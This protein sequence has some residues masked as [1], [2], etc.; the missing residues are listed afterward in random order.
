MR[1]AAAIAAVLLGAGLA[2]CGGDGASPRPP[3]VPATNGIEHLRVVRVLG[4]VRTVTE[5][6]EYRPADGCWSAR[7]PRVFALP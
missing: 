3:A 4:G 2:A 6:R 7:T 1:S 5:S